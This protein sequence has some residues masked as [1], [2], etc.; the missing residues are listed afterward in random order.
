MPRVSRRTFIGGLAAGGIGLAIGSRY[1][2]GEKRAPFPA[3]RA[4]GDILALDPA[5]TGRPPNVILINCD[6]LGYGD[7]GCYGSSA[8]KTPHIDALAAGGMRFTDFH[9]CDSVCTPSR[10]GLLTG[11]YPKRMRLDF[12]LMPSTTA[13]K[14]KLV[15]QLGFAAGSAGVMDMDSEVGAEGLDAFEV[16]M[17]QALQQRG[18]RTAM[19][20]KWHLG[21]FT[22]APQYH[23]LEH[24]FQSFYGVPHSND[25]QPFPLYR[26]RD[27]IEA[28]VQDRTALT[29]LYTDEAIKVI[30]ANTETP[31]FLY[32]AHT[33]PHRPLAAS[34]QFKNTSDGGLYGDTVEEIDWNVGRLMETLTRHHLDANTL[35]LFTSD[36]GPWYDGSPAGFRGRKGQ[37]FEG[38]HRV[39]MIARWNGTI[40]AGRLCEAPTMNI[41]VFPTMLSLAGIGMPSD[42]LIDG[43]SMVNLL[44][45]PDV[46]PA[47]PRELYFYHQG[48]LEGMRSGD[49]KFIR[50]VNHYVWPLPVNQIL[51][52]LSRQTTGPLPL[53]YNLRSD[54]GE[55]YN[56][57]GRYPERVRALNDGMVRWETAMAQNLFG[58]RTPS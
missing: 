58:L 56:L 29:R 10:A 48:T 34:T 4:I 44:T 42:R 7:L 55:A 46:P 24:G 1:L 21:D 28:N 50:T 12:P 49:W 43:E 54:P 20:G 5:F 22:N 11:R 3:P 53:L 31:F 37:S 57:A 52:W 35:V 25:M 9:A 13:I 51:G 8:V 47:T 23:P 36:N 19:I 14:T 6:D 41:D 27:V 16:T 2:L 18:Y 39:P 38:G 40:P 33:Y 15:N 30:E 26:G 32:L 17:G 45:R